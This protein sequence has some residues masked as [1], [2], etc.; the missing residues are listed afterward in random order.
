M[1]QVHS[2]SELSCSI[3]QDQFKSYAVSVLYLLTA[4][5]RYV[6]AEMN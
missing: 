5:L 3:A 2:V 6:M 1:R 4:T